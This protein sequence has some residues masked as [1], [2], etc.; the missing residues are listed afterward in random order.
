MKILFVTHRY[1]PRTG[2]VETHVREIATR[3]VD[4]GHD[5][6][7][8]SADDGSD[9]VTESA[10]DGV[11]VR[12]FRSVS[13]GGAFYVAPQM[14]IAV[15]NADADVLHAHNYHA[16]PLF[17]AALGITDQRFV[18]TMHYH[19]ESA[20]GFRDALLSLYRPFGRW[21]VRQADGVIAV[22]KWEKYQLRE[23]FGVDATV[24]PNGVDVERFVEAE[25]EERERPYLLCVGRLEEYKGVQHVIRALSKLPEYD[26][27][28]A[29]RGPYRDDLER[30]ALDEGVQ[31]RV[32]FLGYVNSERL[33]RLYA[34]ANVYVT[35]SEFE[36]YGMTVAEALASGTRCVVRNEG[37]LR[38]WVGHPNVVSV[39]NPSPER[40]AEAAGAGERTDA[41]STPTTWDSVVDDVLGLYRE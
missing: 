9:V 23:D 17:F 33:P 11:H 20:S 36:A 29:G 2:G 37:A 38:D 13:P 26:L 12:R 27:V 15:R 21:A 30:I 24:I 5:V 8:F 32:E 28:V 41:P 34:G 3:L 35:M 25:P 40:I 7:V 4:R 10:D 1:P 22:S 19:G 18:V 39:H 16:F 14:A 6:T 31:D